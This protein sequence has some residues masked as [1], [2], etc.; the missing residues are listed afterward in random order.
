MRASYPSARRA[1]DGLTEPIRTT[2][3]DMAK[4]KLQALYH[5]SRMPFELGRYDTARIGREDEWKRLQAL[6]DSGRTSQSPI[7]GVLLGSY[8]AG[9]SFLLWHLAKHYSNAVRSKVLASQ[10]IRLI[11]PEQKRDFIKNVVLRLFR[12]GFNTEGLTSLMRAALE[13]SGE[14]PVHVRRFAPLLLAL[15]DKTHAPI[16]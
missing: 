5:L 3:I 9:K 8:G 15:A 12:R 1:P 14:L 10:P 16:A 4:D 6:V 11:D 7:L 2:G 13:T